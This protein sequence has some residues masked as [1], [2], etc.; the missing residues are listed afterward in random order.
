MGLWKLI[1]SFSN[2]SILVKWMSLSMVIVSMENHLNLDL[3]MISI[4]DPSIC[5]PSISK[6]ESGP[7]LQH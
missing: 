4:S 5:L 1:L 2:I 7:K 6:S 3:E